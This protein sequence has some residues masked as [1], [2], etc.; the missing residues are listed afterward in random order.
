MSIIDKAKDATTILFILN[1][2]LRSSRL[3]KFLDAKQRDFIVTKFRRMLM[4]EERAG[5]FA[6]STTN[7]GDS[8]IWWKNTEDAL[9]MRD[10]GELER[11]GYIRQEHAHN[12]LEVVE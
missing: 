9:Y 12:G 1:E 5:T 4:N 2:C 11:M 6:L 10:I 7:F 3:T 8:T